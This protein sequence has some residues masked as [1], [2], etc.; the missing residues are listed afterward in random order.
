MGN[1]NDLMRRGDVMAV[2]EPWQ[3]SNSLYAANAVR[4]ICKQIA[5]LPAATMGVKQLEWR[6]SVRGGNLYVWLRAESAFGD[7]HVRFLASDPKCAAWGFGESDKPIY[8]RSLSDAKAAAQADYEARRADY[9]ASILA[10]L[11][12]APAPTLENGL[13]ASDYEATL[14]DQRRLV[15]ELDIAMHGEKGAAKQASLCDLIEPARQMR[16][17]IEA[18]PA[19][20]LGDALEKARKVCEADA[21]PERVGR[22]SDLR[23]AIGDLRAALAALPE[24]GGA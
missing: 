9:E 13:T 11:E 6:E 12:H 17:K 7:Y 21:E 14:T 18:M 10:A 22:Y 3:Y 5:A 15:R 23:N 16:A 1:K 20:T 8:A 4:D 19:T 24:K 2:V